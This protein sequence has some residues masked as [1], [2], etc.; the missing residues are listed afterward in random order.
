MKI[1][2]S[3]IRSFVTS[4]F[5]PKTNSSNEFVI[6]SP[7]CD[8][9]KGKLYINKDTGVWIDFKGGGQGSFLKFVREYLGL[10]TNSEAIRYL[11][12]NYDLK[13][14]EDKE[15]TKENIDRKKILSDFIRKEGIK[16]FGDGS[17]LGM[18]GKMAYNYAMS[19]KLEKEY[20]PTMGYIFNP[21]SDFNRRVVV[22][23]FEDGRIVYF[24]ARAVD[25]TNPMRYLCIR[26]LDSK[27][28]VFNIDNINEEFVIAEGVFDACSLTIDQAAT[29]L[30]SADIGT[31]QLEKIFDKRPKKI[32]Y[33]PDSDR[34]GQM[35]MDKNIKKILM[36]C[37]YT[38]LEI[39]VYNVPKPF[40]DL[41]EQK[42]ATGKNFILKKEC[43][44]YGSKLFAKSIF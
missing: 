8:D 24:I 25:K 20:Y 33:V 26:K 7:F 40:K 30:L 34:T 29:C 19:R 15:L 6:H 13:Y 16:V 38:G 9:K 10:N 14:E 23:F 39:Y 22:P 12:E 3:L 31:K 44:E 21:S 27:D 5:N 17:E 32:I 41:N 2:S 42:I 35:K 18:F 37:P 43:Y 1:P 4:E 28:Y 11:V 36:Y